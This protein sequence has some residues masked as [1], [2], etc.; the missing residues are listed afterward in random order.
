MKA[1]SVSNTVSSTPQM[2]EAMMSFGLLCL[3]LIL[4]PFFR[5]AAT[6]LGFNPNH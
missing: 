6:S 3:V 2:V 4:H 5:L 1:M